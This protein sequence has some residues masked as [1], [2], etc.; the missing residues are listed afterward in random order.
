M[1]VLPTSCSAQWVVSDFVYVIDR[2]S[3]VLIIIRH[4]HLFVQIILRPQE[5]LAGD[6][7]E[8]VDAQNLVTSEQRDASANIP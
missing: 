6:T 3:A 4:S 5:Y 7:S 1:P 2:L 8:H